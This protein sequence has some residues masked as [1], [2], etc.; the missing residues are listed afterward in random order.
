MMHQPPIQIRTANQAE[1]NRI[2]QL[3]EKELYATVFDVW[4]DSGRDLN[5]S[6]QLW[7]YFCVVVSPV[8]MAQMPDEKELIGILLEHRA[9]I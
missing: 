6:R 8:M 4:A 7:D 5:Y 9:L 2:M 1:S 3:A